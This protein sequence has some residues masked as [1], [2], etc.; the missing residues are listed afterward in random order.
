MKKILSVLAALILVF[1]F[2]ACGEDEPAVIISDTDSSQAQTTTQTTTT[3]TATAVTTT[4]VIDTETVPQSDTIPE[5][6]T[7]ILSNRQQFVCNDN[8]NTMMYFEEIDFLGTPLTPVDYTVIDMDSNGSFDLIVRFKSGDGEQFYYSIFMASGDTVCMTTRTYKAFF[9]LRADGIFG[10]STS[11]AHSGYATMQ[12]ENGIITHVEK[13]AI[14]GDSEGVITC[15]IN[16]QTAVQADFDAFSTAHL[17]KEEPTWHTFNA[18][19]FM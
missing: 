11:A 3:T 5:I 16:G 12:L 13:A 17:A 9:D 7:P 8:D 6:F 2:A 1:A 4:Q 14:E 10:F 18:S 15:R 19:D